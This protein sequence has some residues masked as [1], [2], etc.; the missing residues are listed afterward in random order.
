MLIRQ[1]SATRIRTQNLEVTLLS[2]VTRSV[3]YLISRISR[4]WGA[5]RAYWFDSSLL[6]SAPSQ[7]PLCHSLC[8]AQDYP[9]LGFP[10]F[11][12]FFHSELL[13]RAAKFSRVFPYGSQNRQEHICLIPTESV[14][15][16]ALF[17]PSIFQTLFEQDQDDRNLMQ[18]CIDCTHSY[19]IYHLC[20]EL[21]VTGAFF[22]S[23]LL[24]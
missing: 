12:P 1:C 5:S 2:P 20:I 13:Q 7:L 19:Y 14:S 6:V 21:L 17:H 9:Y 24:P 22:F 23:Q 15:K 10:E 11:T 16:I 18:R 3:D 4:E 8:L